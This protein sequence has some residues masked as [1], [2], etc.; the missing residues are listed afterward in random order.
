ME[1]APHAQLVGEQDP[2]KW[3]LRAKHILDTKHPDVYT[4]LTPHDA[5]KYE[6]DLM[7]ALQE[8]KGFI[9]ENSNAPESKTFEL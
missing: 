9:Q 6:A 7:E 2:E 3:W 1:R 8:L 4:V 5:K